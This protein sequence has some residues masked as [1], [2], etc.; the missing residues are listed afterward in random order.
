MRFR[1]QPSN[2]SLY[3]RFSFFNRITTAFFYLLILFL[4]TAF[5]GFSQHSPIDNPVLPG[6][7][8]AGVLKFNGEYYIG[9]V[10]TK[11]SFYVSPDLVKWEGP[12]HVFSMDN[13]WTE[14]ASAGD[15]QIHAND[16]HYINGL[17]HQYWSVN[18]WGKDKH[19]V[20]I[21]HA[22]S[23]DVLGP[24]EE[25]VKET[26][27]ANRIDPHLFVDDDGKSYLYM[28]KFT[29][30]NTIW[31]RS[32]KD[33]W[34]FDGEP[35]YLFASLPNTWETLDNRVAEGPWVTKYRNRYYLMYNANHTSPNWGNYVLGVAEAG[36]PVGFNH[37]SKYPHPVLQSNQIDLEET[38]VDLLDYSSYAQQSFHYTFDIPTENWKGIHF[39]SSSWKSGIPGFGSHWIK[40]STTRK[41]E[42][43]WK[44][45]QIWARKS[46]TVDKEH[47]DNLVLRIHHDGETKVWL[48]GGLVYEG[49]GRQYINRSLDKNAFS[50]LKR[51]EN[52]LALQ[53]THG[54][55]SAFLD[56]SLFD[57][58]DQEMD[59]VLFSPGQPNILRG[60][61]GFEWWLIYM[62]N[63]NAD[64][65]GQYINRVHFY[66]KKLVV[67]GITGINTVGYH[68]APAAPTFGDLFNQEDPKLWQN[69][70]EVNGGEWQLQ[71]KEVIQRDQEISQA[72]VKSTP[73]AHYLFEVGVKMEDPTTKAGVVAWWQDDAHWLKVLFDPGK[74]SWVY[75]IK[76]GGEVEMFSFPLPDDFKF[77][78]YHSFTILKNAT[79]FTVKIDG[80]PAPHHPEIN[81]PGFFGKGLPGLYTEGANTAFDGVVYTIGWDEFDHT[82]TGWGASSS[83]GSLS[84]SWSVSENGIMA[85]DSSGENFIF[86]GDTLQEYEISLQIASEDNQ[87]MA[88]IFPV[89]V[90]KDNYLKASFDF[91]NHRFMV[92]GKQKGVVMD[93]QTMDVERSKSYYSDIKYSDFIEKHFSFDVTTLIDRIKFNKIPHQ[94]PDSLV[95][96]LYQKV[97][98]FYKEKNNWLPI[99]AFSKSAPTHPDFDEISFEPVMAEALKFIN[100]K[101][102]DLNYYIYKI[103]VNEIFRQSFNLRVVRLREAII[104]VVDGKQ[105]MEL[106]LNFPASQVGLHSTNTKAHFNGITLFH[107]NTHA[108]L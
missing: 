104:F 85:T 74:N 75:L 29:D 93:T 102:D 66:N 77:T 9:G 72:L 50:L 108:D 60:P 26:W 57:M 54:E 80:L 83:E 10:F 63:K 59:D 16:I 84:G 23:T 100:K 55:R 37:G 90:D 101:A 1:K 13:E 7:A 20:H 81:L 67:E 46:F 15:D 61:N 89:F 105:V 39:S 43:A 2:H 99:E 40:N 51:G 97:D 82:I 48:N 42:T 41:V 64:R 11:G 92:S 14:G 62:A 106:K 6:V 36:S 91:E 8:D 88:G 65:R 107:I 103:G 98:I 27:F 71:N 22:T 95:D 49:E 28:V 33:P 24:Y 86:K 25:P 94:Q 5:H 47:S 31:A 18:Y 68:P 78:S 30:G 19:V 35:Q 56:V 12:V 21:G 69:K 44:S 70:W 52:L 73:A 34:T 32:M 53:S 76:D 87:G 17:F 3:F 79:D 38:F 4:G 45:P 58:K 96:D